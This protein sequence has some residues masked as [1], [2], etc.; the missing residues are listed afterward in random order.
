MCWNANISLNTYIFGLFASSFAYYNGDIKMPAFIFYQSVITMQL[1]EYFIWSK[2]FSNRL[3]SQ[4]G[5]LLILSQPIFNIIKIESKPSLI[6]YILIAY[7][8]FVAILYLFI[9]PINTIN[10]SSTPH[11]NGHL[12]WNWLNWNILIVLI[13]YIF[14]TSRWII[15]KIYLSFIFI[16]LLLIITIVLYKKSNTWGS[17]WCWFCNIISFYYILKVFYKDI[18]KI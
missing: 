18:C 14:L 5:L 2:T 3:L 16:T 13:W 1:I 4:L 6:P 15:D 11:K 7:L 17:L 10:F 12:S 8:L 9:I